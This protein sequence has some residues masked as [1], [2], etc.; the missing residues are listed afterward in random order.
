MKSVANIPPNQ[1]Q[2]QDFNVWLNQKLQDPKFR[3]EYEKVQTEFAPVRAIIQARMKRGI[4]QSHIA[5]KMGTTQSAIARVESG[6]ANPSLKFMQ[7][8]ADA[9]DL[10]LDIRFLPR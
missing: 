5:K 9:L 2:H 6:S 4:T 7:K 1:R 3:R 8:L 10:R